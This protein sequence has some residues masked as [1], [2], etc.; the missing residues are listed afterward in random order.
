VFADRDGYCTLQALRAT[1]TLRGYLAVRSEEP[2]S[3]HDRVLV[4]HAMSLISIEMDKPAKVLDAEPG[5]LTEFLGPRLARFKH[6]KD[7]VVVDQLPR[8]AG[9]KVLK[10]VLRDKFGSSGAR[11]CRPAP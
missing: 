9:G 1:Q 6:P 8:N 10:T 5:D 11:V 7:V 2:L 4:A 3:A